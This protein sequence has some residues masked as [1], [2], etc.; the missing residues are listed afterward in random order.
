MRH[1]VLAALCSASLLGLAACGGSGGS[2]NADNAPATGGGNVAPVANQG[3]SQPAKN[4]PT[5][6]KD[7]P[8]A[9]RK[10]AHSKPAGWVDLSKDGREELLRHVKPLDATFQYV[11][12]VVNKKAPGGTEGQEHWEHWSKEAAGGV[13]FFVSK[14]ALDPAEAVKKFAPA[15]AAGEPEIKKNGDVAWTPMQGGE[16]LVAALNTKLGTYIVVGVVLDTPNAGA[17]HEALV[18]W[19]KSVKPE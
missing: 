14:E 4:Q 13:V 10:V 15:V 2:A 3:G 18:G 1:A 16:V 9:F 5:P 6:P 7:D 12:A 8:N 19:A 17:Y 11:A